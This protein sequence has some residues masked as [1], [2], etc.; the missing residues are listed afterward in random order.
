MELQKS[1]PLNINKVRN[2]IETKPQ[3]VVVMLACAAA[4]SAYLSMY[5]FRKPLSASTYSDVASLTILG[6]AFDF[7][8]IALI[9]QLLGYMCSKFL[10][11]KFA[12]E[13]PLSR[14][15]P[16][17]LCLIGFA[18]LMLVMFAITPAPYNLIFLFL[19]GL[20]LGMVWSMLFGILEGRRG[21][22]VS[23]VGDERQYYFLIGLG[24]G[25]RV[26]DDSVAW[27]PTVL[28]ACADWM[29]VLSFIAAFAVDALLFAASKRRR[30]CSEDRTKA[31]EPI[32]SDTVF[33]ELLLGCAGIDRILRL[34]HHL[35]RAT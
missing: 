21:L 18:W 4:F 20:P 23:W 24:K 31:D 15:A 10:G 29:S 7:K 25:C 9:S 1:N 26:V 13:A 11:V 32:R 22:R 12:S 8:A 16:Y 28:D 2:W 33:Q 5:A 3:F 35:S 27:C 19:N 17:V 6:V 14:R 34:P 30:H